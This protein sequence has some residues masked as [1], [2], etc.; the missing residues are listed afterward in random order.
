[1]AP[2]MVAYILPCPA[3]YIAITVWGLYLISVIGSEDLKLELEY[4]MTA[5]PFFIISNYVS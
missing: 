3:D 1:M 2:A 4:N 5:T